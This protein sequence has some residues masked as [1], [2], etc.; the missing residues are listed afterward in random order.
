MDNTWKKWGSWPPQDS[1]IQPSTTKTR[2]RNQHTRCFFQQALGNR[3]IN[4]A[5]IN[6]RKRHYWLALSGG[7][8]TDSRD[9]R[10]FILQHSIQ[11]PLWLT[12]GNSLMFFQRWLF[13]SHPD[14][15]MPETPRGPGWTLH[16]TFAAQGGMPRPRR[17]LKL[18]IGASRL[19]S[20][21]MDDHVNG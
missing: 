5:N 4:N 9:S 17:I 16:R 1:W 10:G 12:E 2:D 20:I 15:P 13:G 18:N 3:S 8:W 14:G 6:T 7:N 11:K 19:V 21:P